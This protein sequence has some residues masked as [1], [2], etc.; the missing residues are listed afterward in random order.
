MNF[1]HSTTVLMDMSLKPRHA[2]VDF[3]RTYVDERICDSPTILSPGHALG[4]RSYVFLSN[5]ERNTGESADLVGEVIPEGSGITHCVEFWYDISA[6]NETSLKPIFRGTVGPASKPGYIALDDISISENDRCET[7]PKGADQ[8]DA[9]GIIYTN[10]S[11]LTDNNNAMRLV[12]PILGPQTEAAC[13]SFWYHL[14]AGRHTELGLNQR[15]ADELDKAMKQFTVLFRHSDRTTVDRWNKAE[16]LVDNKSQV[17]WKKTPRSDWMLARV[18]IVQKKSFQV[19]FRAIFPAKNWRTLS[20]DNVALR[21]EPCIHSAN[22]D[23]VEGLCGYVNKFT[24]NFRW[25]IGTGR[26]ENPKLQ[27][28]VPIP[29]GT[30]ATS[31]Q[32]ASR[33]LINYITKANLSVS[34]YSEGTTNQVETQYSEDL[35]EVTEWTELTVALEKGSNCQLAVWVIRGDG[36]DGAIAIHSVKVQQP[37]TMCGWTS[38][39]G[40]MT[41]TLNDPAKKVPDYPRFDHTKRAYNARDPRIHQT[42]TYR[43]RRPASHLRTMPTIRFTKETALRDP[44]MSL[45]TRIEGDWWNARTVTVTS[46]TQWNLVFE[47]VAPAGTER[48]SGVMVDDVEFTDGQCPPYGYYLLYRSSGVKGNSTA[49]RLREPSRYAC[50]S[51]WYFLPPTSDRVSLLLQ[52]ESVKSKKKA[53]QKKQ[54]RLSREAGDATIKVISGSNQQSFVALDDILLSEEDCPEERGRIDVDLYMTTGGYA[55]IVWSLRS[56]QGMPKEDVWNQ[57]VVDVGRY[58]AEISCGSSEECIPLAKVCDFRD[59]CSNAADEAK[60]GACEFS[61]DLCGLENADPNA[62]FGWTWRAAQ[63]AIH[64]QDFPTTDSRNYEHGFYAAYSLLNDGAYMYA[65]NMLPAVKK[66]HL[67]SIRMSPTTDTGRCFTFWYNMWHPNSGELNL[68]QRVDNIS[69]SLLWTRSGPQGKAWQQAQVQLFSDEPHQVSILLYHFVSFTAYLKKLLLPNVRIKGI[70]CTFE[71]GSCGWQLHNWEVTKGSSVILPSTDHS[72]RAPPGSF[73]RVRPPNGRMVSPEGWYEAT[74]QRCLRF[75]FFTA[76]STAE[77]LNVTQVVNNAQGESLWFRT[78]QFVPT[79]SWYSAAVNLTGSQENSITVFEGATSGNPGTAVAVD[80]ISLGAEPCPKPGSCSFEEDMCNWH[81]D[82][83]SSHAQWYRHRGRTIFTLEEPTPRTEETTVAAEVTTTSASSLPTE[84]SLWCSHGEFSCGDDVTCI[85]SLLQCDGV[86]D[87]PNGRDE[88]CMCP[89][90]YCLNG[91][92]C[93][94][95]TEQMSPVCNCSESHEGIRC[96][97]PAKPVQAE[98]EDRL[99]GTLTMVC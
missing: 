50:S 10:G 51:L 58:A 72:T 64:S 91:G 34:C 42:W 36:K 78:A 9:G 41:W 52:S 48:L 13:F 19:V 66:A 30:Y 23:F 17:I 6:D 98:Q 24:R 70:V 4:T 90:K 94:W 25:L 83:G 2:Y 85:P 35:K 7:L 67:V 71:S 38:D 12:S 77:T 96:Q 18:Q 44:L 46:A 87:C 73:A 31:P 95:T 11:I 3:Q 99:K 40:A 1:F 53:W 22:C 81:N 15:K 74:Q 5:F 55:I 33:R 75:W 79:N 39:G 82:K 37:G 16:L 29:Q 54:F 26:L 27:P 65:Q 80:D 45:R 20:L 59:D 49:L 21:P 62:R 47:V 28:K 14:F 68:L 84:A 92:T 32:N 86:A 56:V 61:R 97:L 63:D 69:S 43:S 57:V 93:T 8:L 89:E 88:D 60:C 76:G